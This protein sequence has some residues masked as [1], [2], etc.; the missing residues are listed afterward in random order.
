[1]SAG[2]RSG[3]ICHTQRHGCS[4]AAV[5]PTHWASRT[6]KG[7]ASLTREASL[8]CC[9]TVRS[10]RKGGP[11]REWACITRM[12]WGGRRRRWSFLP[13]LHLLHLLP[14]PLGPCVLPPPNQLFASACQGKLLGGFDNSVLDLLHGS[15]P[16]RWGVTGHG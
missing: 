7:K 2:C 5:T 14:P 16:V 1:M 12:P 13:L 3:K 6:F 10:V 15:R 11:A 8:C 4:P 9:W